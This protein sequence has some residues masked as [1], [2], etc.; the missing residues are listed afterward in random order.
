MRVF[1]D[2]APSRIAQAIPLFAPAFGFAVSRLFTLLGRYPGEEQRVIQLPVKE[3]RVS[4]D[5]L[6]IRLPTNR[7]RSLVGELDDGQ[8]RPADAGGETIEV[9]V[10]MEFKVRGG[11]KKIILPPDANTTPDVGPQRPLVVALARAFRWQELLDTGQAGCIA[12]LARKY[13][14]DRSYI[15]QI[16]K[17]TS[18]APDIVE[19][20]LAGNEPSGLSLG[21]LRGGVPMA[22]DKQREGWLK[23]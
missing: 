18:L 4:A 15:G 11:R 22:W 21:T 12:E 19:A 14:V 5:G 13:D 1:L 2:C 10:P 3:V 20:I 8:K 23:Q 16:L 6:M 17:L 9:H 7:L